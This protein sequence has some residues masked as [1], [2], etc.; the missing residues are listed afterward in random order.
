[1]QAYRLILRGFFA[2]LF[3]SIAAMGASA[4]QPDSGAAIAACV[5]PGDEERSLSSFSEAQRLAL[6]ACANRLAAEQI[7]AQTPMRVDDV[8][9]LE[10]VTVSGTTVI[11]HQRVDIDGRNVTPAMKTSI[12]QAVRTRVCGSENMRNTIVNGGAYA[13]N[14]VDRSGA[15]LHRLEIRAC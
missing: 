4:Q 3:I 10:S 15:F 7:N 14:W 6:I 1:M 9:T 11:Y 13:Y 2:L 12:D 8:T 5:A